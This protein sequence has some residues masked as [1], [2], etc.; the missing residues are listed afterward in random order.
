MAKSNYLE[1]KILDYIFNDGTFA[2]PQTFVSL[3][4]SSPADDDSGTEVSGTNYARQEVHE[5]AGTSPYWNLA[6][7]DGVG[8]LVDNQSAITFP[9]AG[10][11]GWGSVSHF[12]IHDAVSTGNL[13]YHGALTA[14]QTVNDGS[15]FEFAAGDL[16]IREE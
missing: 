14:S 1:Q 13:L 11:G 15:T 2:A 12:G 3:Y 5:N 8:Y 7:V 10:A 9:T 4:T 6:A 16:N